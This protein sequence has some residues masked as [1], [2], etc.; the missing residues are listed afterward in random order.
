MEWK[1]DSELFDL[2]RKQLYTAIVGDVMDAHERRRQFLP[3]RCRPLRPDMVVAGRA[4]TV[5]EADVFHEPDPPFGLMLQAL[6]ALQPNEIYCAAG[7]G[8]RFALWGE[9]MSTAARARG[10]T[11]A[12][13]AGY[14]RDT[15][16]IFALDFPV[17]CYGSYAQDQRGRGQV[18]AFRVPIE[19]DGV[20]VRPG[21]ILFGDIDGVLVVPREIEGDVITEALERSRKEKKAKQELAEGRL[22]EEVFR[23]YGIL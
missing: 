21:D 18:I 7:C 2:M 11:G 8:A 23:K 15:H 16:G 5:L 9:L 17:F 1:T 20:V 22:A 6:D 10:A 14:T 3:A 19:V 12:V 13:L 4:M